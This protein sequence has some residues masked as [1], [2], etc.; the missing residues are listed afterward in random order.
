MKHRIGQI[1]VVGLLLL[2]AACQTSIRQPMCSQGELAF[3]PG[4]EGT[5]RYTIMT[6]SAA[7]A[8]SISTVDSTE[9]II[10]DVGNTYELEVD[11]T[12]ATALTKLVK[13]VRADGDGLP[14]MML[15][16]CRIGDAYYVQTMDDAGSYNLQRFDL[17]PT[18]ITLTSLA[19]R[20]EDLQEHGFSYV[21]LPMFE[22]VDHRGLWHFQMPES[23]KVIVDNSD[24]TVQRREELVGIAQPT[25]IG[26]VM[27]RIGPVPPRLAKL[28]AGG[29][30]ILLNK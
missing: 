9:F 5:Y 8:N 28:Q 20:P 19:W 23:T 21:Y 17:S 4:A 6:Q 3:P 22:N 27:T 16:T 1:A 15:E 10:R 29:R 12:G 2:S 11:K 7:H 30:R 13:K 14:F 25:A 24:L 26:I 18:A